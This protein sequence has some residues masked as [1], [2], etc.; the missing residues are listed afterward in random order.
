MR[1]HAGIELAGFCPQ[2]TAGLRILLRA[3]K[4]DRGGGS[5]IPALEE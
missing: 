3:S 5:L 1:Q 4:P 2:D